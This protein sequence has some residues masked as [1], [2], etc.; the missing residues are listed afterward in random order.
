MT[1]SCNVSR[2]LHADLAWVQSMGGPLI[3]IPVSALDQWVGCT[4]DGVIVGGT[5]VPD[6]YDR[7]C[8]VEGWAGTVEVGAEGSGLVLADEPATT[9]YLPEQNIFLRWLAAD[10][11]AE[12][13]EAAAKAVIED[14]ATAW[15]NCGVWDVD[16]AA[17]L[18]DSAVA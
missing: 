9:C 18:L 12:L 4:E 2:H 13:L 5:D 15:E 3:A 16:G 7:A 8:D 10:S 6:D 1:A 11:D 17:V 14:P